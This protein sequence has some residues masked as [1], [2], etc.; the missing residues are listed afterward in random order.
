[1]SHRRK[2]AAAP[3]ELLPWQA[4]LMVLCVTVAGLFHDHPQMIHPLVAGVD[5][6]QLRSGMVHAVHS[7]DLL[8]ATLWLTR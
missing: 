5:A 8:N 1:M 7:G 4:V 3:L 2:T 6:S